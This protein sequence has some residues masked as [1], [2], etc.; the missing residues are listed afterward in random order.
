L[1]RHPPSSVIVEPPWDCTGWRRTQRLPRLIR[2]AK[3]LEI[4]LTAGK[5]DVCD[6][7][8]LGLVDRER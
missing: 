5:L 6:A 3:A 2:K 4:F 1:P 7:L 8:R